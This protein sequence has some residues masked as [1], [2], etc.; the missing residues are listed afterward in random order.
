MRELTPIELKEVQLKIMDYVDSF[1]RKNNIQYTLAF[2][3]LLGAERHGGFIPWDDDI[4]IQLLRPEYEKFTTLWNAKKSE[5]PYVLVNIES[6]NNMG[7]PFGKVYDPST[8]TFVGNVQR[9][10]VF[11]DVFPVDYVNNKEDYL[12]RS[13]E[14]DKL[15]KKRYACFNW[16]KVNNS[17][18]PV[19]KKIIPFLRKPIKSYE[20]LAIEISNLAKKV[21]GK[22]DIACDMING[23]YSKELMKAAIYEEY[24]DIKF[25]DRVYRSVKDTDTYLTKTYGDWRTPPP[26]EK[27]ISHHGFKAYWK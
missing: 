26:P 24:N 5:H 8:V 20:Q 3:T 14:I 4:D 16:M 12:H 27:Q 15:I 2:G 13:K 21:G 1:C 19:Y 6:G 11:I 23:R 25:E 18:M 7:Y 10:G 22:T 9:T 17:K